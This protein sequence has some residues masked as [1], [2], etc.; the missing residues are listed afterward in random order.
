MST[1]TVDDW[2]TQQWD[3]AELGDKRRSQR[4]VHLGAQMAAHPAAGLPGQTQSW[5]D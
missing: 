2:A 1:S 3:S 4:A 5:G